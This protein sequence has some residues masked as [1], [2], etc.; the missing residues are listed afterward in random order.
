MTLK[1][2]LELEQ[3]HI[4]YWALLVEFP[5]TAKLLIGKRILKF[6]SPPNMPLLHQRMRKCVDIKAQTGR[7]VLPTMTST[8]AHK[9]RSFER[10]G[11]PSS[12]SL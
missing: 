7:P 1:T 11:T 8:T 4:V 3:V 12:P 9:H 5:Q 10:A 2:L 6:N